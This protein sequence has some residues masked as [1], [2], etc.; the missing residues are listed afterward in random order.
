MAIQQIQK[1]ARSRGRRGCLTSKV[2]AQPSQPKQSGP[3][4]PR[5][6][7]GAEPTVRGVSSG[8]GQLQ[9]GSWLTVV[10]LSLGHG[11]DVRHQAGLWGHGR[12]D[13]RGCCSQ[14][15]LTDGKEGEVLWNSDSW[16]P[17]PP[18]AHFTIHGHSRAEDVDSQEAGTGQACQAGPFWS[19]AVR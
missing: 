3:G 15:A 17:G 10:I 12:Q 11:S 4:S 5:T 1:P 8:H 9:R 16:S 13:G 19:R 18:S 7:P 6:K 14:G 2:S